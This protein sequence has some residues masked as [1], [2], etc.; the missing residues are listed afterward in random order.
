LPE[1]IELLRQLTSQGR[2][3]GGESR[4]N[5]FSG[6]KALMFAVFEDGVRC[7]L[8][9]PGEPRTA[10][11]AWIRSQRSSVFSF[12]AVSELLGFNPGAVRDALLRLRQELRQVR[13]VRSYTRVD[14][15]LS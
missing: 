5:D 10:A 3:G 4:A 11:E 15:E 9:P 14:Q 6:I 8:G 2:V 1:T 12:I 7:Y 13:R